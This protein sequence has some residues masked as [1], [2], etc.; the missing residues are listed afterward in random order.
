MFRKY[1]VTGLALAAFTVPALAA[2]SYYVAQNATSKKCE[3]VSKKPDGKT[4]MMI[5]GKAFTSK[6][7]ATTALK[8]DK[9]C[10]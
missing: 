5:G 1:V 8:A 7:E 2:T 10:K 6:A 9:D 3:V 4:W